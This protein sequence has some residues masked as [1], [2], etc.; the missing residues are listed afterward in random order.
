MI[1]TTRS[2]DVVESLTGT[3]QYSNHYLGVF[4]MNLIYIKKVICIL[5]MSGIQ[6]VS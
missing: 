3:R 5:E 4:L 2:I 1:G 6:L